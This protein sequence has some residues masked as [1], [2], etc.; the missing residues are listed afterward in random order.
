MEQNENRDKSIKEHLT[1]VLNEKA[2]PEGGLEAE[3]TDRP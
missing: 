2:E 3:E 1:R